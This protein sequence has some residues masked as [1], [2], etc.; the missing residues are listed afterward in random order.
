MEFNDSSVREFNFEKLKSECYGGDG[1][2]GADDGWSFGSS[3]GKSAY[4]L[5]Y[6]RRVKRPL[7]ILV[8]KDEVDN[9]KAKGEAIEY[10][11]KKE[12]HFKLIDYRE[13][14]EDIAP[15]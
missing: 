13:G 3:Y 8:D 2:A 11:D 12:E 15:N 14:V 7:K 9:L 4:M 1:K 10:D 6:E 5:V